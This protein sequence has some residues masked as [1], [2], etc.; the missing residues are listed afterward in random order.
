LTRQKYTIIDVVFF[1]CLHTQTIKIPTDKKTNKLVEPGPGDILTCEQC[2]LQRLVVEVTNQ[3]VVYYGA[4][5][6]IAR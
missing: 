6:E 5:T 2:G 4:D 1:K 3:R